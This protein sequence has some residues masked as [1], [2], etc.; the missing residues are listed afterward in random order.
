MSLISRATSPIRPTVCDSERIVSSV[1]RLPSTAR[2]VTSPA[3]VAWRVISRIEA[4]SSLLAAATAWTLSSAWPAAAATPCASPPSRAAA[5]AMA[6]ASRATAP[7]RS[8]TLATASRASRS[9]V[10]AM[11]ATALRRSSPACWSSSSRSCIKQAKR[12]RSARSCEATVQNSR[13]AGVPITRPSSPPAIAAKCPSSARSGRRSACSTSQPSQAPTAAQA[14]ATTSAWTSRAEKS[15]CAAWNCSAASR[16]CSPSTSCAASRAG[17][18]RGVHPGPDMHP[19]R[20]GVAPLGQGERRLQPFSEESRPRLGEALGDGAL[21]RRQVRRRAPRPQPAEAL[22]AG[23]DRGGPLGDA[24]RGGRIRRADPGRDPRGVPDAHVHQVERLAEPQGRHRPVLV[25]D[26]QRPG[27]G[28]H[29][30]QPQP[31]H[32]R[33]RHRAHRDAGREPAGDAGGEDAQPRAPAG[34]DDF[35]VAQADAGG[36]APALAQRGV[37]ALGPLYRGAVGAEA[38]GD[39]ALDL[40][41]L[42]HRGD[43]GADPVVVAMFGAVLDQPLPRAP[44]PDRGPKIPERLLRHVRVADDVVRRPRQLRLREA[45]DLDEGRVAEQDAPAGIGARD[46]HLVLGDGDLAVGDRLVDAHGSPP[47]WRHRPEGR[48]DGARDCARSLKT[49]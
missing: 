12:A 8:A 14:R 1:R 21:L 18:S 3:R 40:A 43:V 11:S 22:D 10:S 30:R 32:Q 45:A 42:D 33:H 25:G 35:A 31:A 7:V 17:C 46:Q 15:A 6:S 28:M 13:A 29:A 27:R 49:C 9:T 41:L 5:S 36:L 24:G 38:D 44:G 34:R 48:R 2:R 4:A 19:Q 23:A 16:A 20:R 37:G 39:V 26:A 47:P